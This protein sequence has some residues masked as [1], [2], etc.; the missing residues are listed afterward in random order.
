MDFSSLPNFPLICRRYPIVCPD[1][2]P[3][4]PSPQ[5]AR[6]LWDL[7]LALILVALL[8]ELRGVANALDRPPMPRPALLPFDFEFV[9]ERLGRHLGEL[10]APV[11]EFLEPYGPPIPGYWQW[12]SDPARWE[13]GFPGRPL[14]SDSRADVGPE[15]S[16]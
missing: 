1:D 9:V 4:R 5:V 8:S 3:Q 11:K 6:I 7:V 14:H 15:Q 13:Q 12:K 2:V 16:P 10:L